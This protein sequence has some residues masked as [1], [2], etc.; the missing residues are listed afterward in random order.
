MP[1]SSCSLLSHNPNEAVQASVNADIR[2]DG[3]FRHISLHPL[4]VPPFCITLQRTPDA[5]HLVCRPPSPRDDLADPA[6]GLA[7]GRNH[8]YRACILQ[9]IFSGHRLGADARVGECNV[10]WDGFGQV[11]ANHEHL[12]VSCVVRKAAILRY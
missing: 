5:L 10:F 4:I 7:V 8:R 1:S 12:R 9:D 3:I 11:M 6:H 2:V